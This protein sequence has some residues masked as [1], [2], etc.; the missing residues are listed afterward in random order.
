MSKKIEQC[1]TLMRQLV[2]DIQGAP[3][4]GEDFELELYRIWYEHAQKVAVECFEYMEEQF[5]GDRENFEKSID[6]LLK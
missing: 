6:K 5:P 3:Y 4:P 2:T 1:V